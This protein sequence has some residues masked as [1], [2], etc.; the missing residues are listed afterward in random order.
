MTKRLSYVPSY[1]GNAAGYLFMAG[2]IATMGSSALEVIVPIGSSPVEVGVRC[3][4]GAAMY[5]AGHE[6]NASA[7]SFRRER[8]ESNLAIKVS[9]NL[10]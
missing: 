1:L 6:I 9:E 5:Y 8:R 7:N 2:G 4:M 3:L 10:E